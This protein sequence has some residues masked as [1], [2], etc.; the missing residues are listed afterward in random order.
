MLNGWLAYQTLGCRIWGR[1]AFYQSG[2]AFGFRDQLQDA[3]ALLPLWPDVARRQ[4]LLHAAHQF[5]EGD[6][7]HWWHPPLS[8]GIRTRFADD[9][10]WLP[11]L[12]AHYVA[13][14]GDEAILDEVVPYLTARALAPGEDEAYVTPEPAAET[15]DLYDHCCRALDRSLESART[16]CRC[17]APATGTTA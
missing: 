9:L 16:A 6:V 4:I 11:Y 7:L 1:T 8:R 12:A 17:S 14:T 15:G 3:L 13:A 2:G 5:R 10:L